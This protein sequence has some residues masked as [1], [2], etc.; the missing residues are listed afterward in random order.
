M[1]HTVFSASL[2][3]LFNI[4]V[5]GVALEKLSNAHQKNNCGCDEA[6]PPGSCPCAY[7][8][9]LPGSNRCLKSCPYSNWG[10]CA[11]WQAGCY[12][13][14]AGGFC[15][16][17]CQKSNK[18]V[19]DVYYWNDKRKMSVKA[20]LTGPDAQADIGKNELLRICILSASQNGCK[21]NIGAK[22][23][24]CYRNCR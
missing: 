15:E 4:C 5:Q 1:R 19:V 7:E 13:G 3:F 18:A 20:A 16:D 11:A 17:W 24:L 6:E 10:L 14:I 21:R 8:K 22:V 9:H 12:C 2:F 23:P